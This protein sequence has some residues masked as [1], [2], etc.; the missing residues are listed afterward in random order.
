[1]L[2]LDGDALSALA[3]ARGPAVRRDRV[4]AL[5]GEM[6]RRGLPVATVAASL[7]EVVGGR[8]PGSPGSSL[9]ATL[10]G[11]RVEVHAVDAALGLRAGRLLAPAGVPADLALAAFLVAAADL[12]GGAVIAT[13]RPGDMDRLAARA[14]NVVVASIQA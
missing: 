9:F 11:D 12:A 8:P 6:R 1:M 7:A 2:L 14:R 3:L 5:M 4:R 13:A 10:G